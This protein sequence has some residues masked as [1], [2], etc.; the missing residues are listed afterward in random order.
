MHPTIVAALIGII[1]G[2]VAAVCGV[3]GGVVMVPAFVLLLK[4]GSKG[5][6]ATSLAAIV[7]TGAMHEL[8][9]PRERTH[10]LESGDSVRHCGWN[11]WMARGRMD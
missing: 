7:L 1:G 8:Q 11:C 3:G 6:V 9:E 5:A 4:N 10:P 2:V